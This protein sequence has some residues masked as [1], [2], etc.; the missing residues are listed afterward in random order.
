M[1]HQH[2]TKTAT[3]W[4]LFFCTLQT[5]RLDEPRVCSSWKTFSLPPCSHQNHLQSQHHWCF[6]LPRLLFL[7]WCPLSISVNLNPKP[8]VK[9]GSNSTG[10]HLK[11]KVS[12]EIPLPKPHWK[13]ALAVQS[14][15]LPSPAGTKHGDCPTPITL[16]AN[17]HQNI[18]TSAL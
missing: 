4:G 3:S 14:D 17:L 16:F 7:L 9:D 18:V 8:K 15:H 11:F 10:L 6:W 13:N 2:S 5:C 12:F 1:V